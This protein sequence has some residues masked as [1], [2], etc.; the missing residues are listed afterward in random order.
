MSENPLTPKKSY[1]ADW[2]VQGVLTKIGDAFDR[3]TGRGWKPSSSLATSEVIER[4]KKLMDAEVRENGDHRKYVPHNIK[5]KMQWDKFSTDSETGLDKLR[6]E[7]LTAAVDH[8]NDRRYYTYA[9]LSLEVKPDYFTSGVKLLVSFDKFEDEREAE[10]N[11]SIPGMK[12][13]DILPEKAATANERVVA[14]FTASGKTTERTLL[15]EEGKRLSIGRTKENDLP[16]D[17]SSVSKFHASLMLNI[18]GRLVVA[19][20][21]STNGTFVNDERI[22]YGKAVTLEPS[23]KI[24]FGAIDVT[25]E[26]Q[27]KPENTVPL[28]AEVPA[29][30]T[31]TVGE[32]EFTKKIDTVVPAAKTEASITASTQPSIDPIEISREE[33]FSD[34]KEQGTDQNETYREEDN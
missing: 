6:D 29:T 17:D 33:T 32:F 12:T 20:T 11:V 30:E 24:R 5:L 7:M 18:E 10:I 15:L 14:R 4:L 13:A 26:I 31:F 21:G 28:R 22:A 25:L 19:D 9:P 34:N 2:L 27:A 8:I 16:V 23:D 1:S 3:F